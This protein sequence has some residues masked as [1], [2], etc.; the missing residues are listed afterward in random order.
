M[1]VTEVVAFTKEDLESIINGRIY[2]FMN[3]G[4]DREILI[5]TDEKYEKWKDSDFDDEFLD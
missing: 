4:D 3:P 1:R 2:A 5:M